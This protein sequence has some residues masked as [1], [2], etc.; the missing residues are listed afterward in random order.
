MNHS[1]AADVGE[2]RCDGF[3]LLM[4]LL[5]CFRMGTLSLKL[6]DVELAKKATAEKLS[7]RLRSVVLAV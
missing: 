3:M 6:I 2:L 7:Y 4:K 5:T 1:V